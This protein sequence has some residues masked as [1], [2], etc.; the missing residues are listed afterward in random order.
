MMGGGCLV[1]GG[2]L[3][4]HEMAGGGKTTNLPA[5]LTVMRVLK[6]PESTKCSPRTGIPPY[7]LLHCCTAVVAWSVGGGWVVGV[8]MGG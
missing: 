7:M 1:G 4:I 2:S 8:H 3:A 6:T 5:F